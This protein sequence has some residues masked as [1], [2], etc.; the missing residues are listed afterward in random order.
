MTFIDCFALANGSLA[1][2]NALLGTSPNFPWNSCNGA[3]APRVLTPI[4]HPLKVYVIEAR[5]GQPVL[6]IH[7]GNSFAMCPYFEAC[8]NQPLRPPSTATR[9]LLKDLVESQFPSIRIKVFDF[10]G[11]AC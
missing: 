8:A 2:A 3:E 10:G 9:R 4:V 6:M 5:E 1:V 7:G 11:F